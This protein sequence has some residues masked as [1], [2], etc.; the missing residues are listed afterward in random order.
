MEPNVDVMAAFTSS[1]RFITSL[2]YTV[3]NHW[4]LGVGIMAGGSANVLDT[5]SLV[6]AKPLQ[7]AR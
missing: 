2:Q 3:C 4:Y 6:S 1:M 7:S 5:S